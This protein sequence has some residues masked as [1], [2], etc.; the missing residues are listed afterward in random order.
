MS[1]GNS[2]GGVWSKLFIAALV[3]ILLGAGGFGAF[4]L[5]ASNSQTELNSQIADLNKQ[6]ADS[7]GQ[8]ANLQKDLASSQEQ[9][10][11]L[12]SEGAKTQT[13]LSDANFALSASETQLS[14]V[15]WQL[16]GLQSDLD[17][18]N[19]R[20]RSSVTELAGYVAAQAD[21]QSQISA[22]QTNLDR[23]KTG[24]GYLFKDPTYAAMKSFMA[25]DQTDKNKYVTNA[26]ECDDFSADTILAAAKQNIRCAFVTIDFPTSA[27]AVVAFQT[28]DRGL[29]Y[30]EPQSDE[31]VNLQV[32]KRYYQSVIAAPGY[33][34]PAP[35]YDDTVERFTVIW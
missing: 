13:L 2:S 3:V 21:F 25:A 10:A 17:T 27:H 8:V 1:Q 24:Y 32:G 16:S 6:L 20:V 35:S 11:S 28:T 22:L 30:I 23:M 18:A 34:Y 19:Q 9:V 15:R 29:I 26:Y 5:Q 7:K 14:S 31:E 33:Y 4:Y 12:E